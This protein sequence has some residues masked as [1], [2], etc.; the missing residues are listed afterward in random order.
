MEYDIN[1]P[2][3]LTEVETVQELESLAYK[4][5]VQRDIFQN[6]LNMVKQEI[7][8]RNKV[9]EASVKEIK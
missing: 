2:I 1:K 9:E 7:D 4:F 5:T 8:R 3:Q 6:N